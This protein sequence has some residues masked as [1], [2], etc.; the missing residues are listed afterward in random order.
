MPAQRSL[1]TR[2]DSRLTSPGTAPSLV[3]T[4]ST[5]PGDAQ[6]SAGKFLK[7]RGSWPMSGGCSSF[8]PPR[9]TSA[10]MSAPVTSSERPILNRQLHRQEVGEHLGG[11]PFVR[12]TVVDGTVAL[13]QNGHDSAAPARL[14]VCANRTGQLITGCTNRSSEV[15][16]PSERRC[17]VSM[18]QCPSTRAVAASGIA[19]DNSTPGLQREV[20]LWPADPRRNASS[21]FMSS[22][23][24]W[25]PETRPAC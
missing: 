18:Q 6:V 19:S 13:A 4:A 9:R 22:L 8:G 17:A 11:M 15:S 12:E 7:V 10:P 5:E 25:V 14:P 20:V 16:R 3:D 21:G 2:A 1:F 23:I 24:V